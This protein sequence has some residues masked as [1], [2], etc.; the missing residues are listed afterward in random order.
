MLLLLLA[1][2]LAAGV[3]LLAARSGRTPV[4]AGLLASA[5]TF[6][7]AVVAAVGRPAGEAPLLAGV[8]AGFA[9]DGLSAVLVVLVA[10]ALLAS[11]LVGAA[12]PAL[13]TG[14]YVGLMLVFAGAMLATV[15]ATTLPP[16]LMAWEVMGA[17]SWALIGYHLDDARAAR[18]ANVAFC[19]TRAA[20]LGLYV[21]GGA[22]LAGGADTMALGDVAGLGGGWSHVA[23]AG[24]VLAALGKSAQLPFGF[25]LS[26]AMRG[27]SPVS[28]LLHSATMVAAGGYLLLRLSPALE[29]AGWAAPLVAWVGAAT[30]L[31]MG[32]VALAQ[33]DLKQL[34]AASTCAQIGFIVLAAG[35]AGTPAGLLQMT[36]HA[37]TKSALFLVAGLWLATLGSRSLGGGLRG[38][39]RRHPVIGAA[40]TLATLTLAGL[41][42]TGLWLAKDAVLAAAATTSPALYVTGLAAALIAALYSGRALWSVWQ[43]VPGTEP[44]GRVR[45][46]AAATVVTMILAVAAAGTGL[47]AFGPRALRP[48]PAP[49]AA[50]LLASALLA[51]AGLLL[52][53]RYGRRAPAPAPLIEWL[54]LERA[55]RNGVARPV[56]HLATAL[57][58]VDDRVLARGTHRV[59]RAVLALAHRTDAVGER[60]LEGVVGG[61]ADGAR[62]LGR[63]ARRPQTGQLHQYYAQASV[64]FVLLGALAVLVTVVR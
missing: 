2:P 64:G 30:A 22:V 57:A 34:L 23:V 4:A 47:L 18:A 15:T 20:D 1:W 45:A 46:P 42:P 39:A 54:Y 14:R 19:T 38:A 11:L 32:L 37:A 26:G 33:D 8:P 61:I 51:V 36:A 9:V 21:A 48:H 29:S 31:L 6:G 60:A 56:L 17:T 7:L 41:P 27:P 35:T 5:G 52:A 16:L 25:W 53:R 50:K 40:F 49:H 62:A 44:A 3:A 10:A 24:I 28:A 13:R 55:A 63:A 58:R 12:E 59:A 43:P